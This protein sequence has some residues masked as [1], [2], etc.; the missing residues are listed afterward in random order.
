MVALEIFKS[1]WAFTPKQRWPA[2]LTLIKSRSVVENP[3]HTL[4]RHRALCYSGKKVSMASW[5]LL[6]WKSWPWRQGPPRLLRKATC[7][8]LHGKPQT[9]SVWV[10]TRSHQLV[11][12]PQS[13]VSISGTLPPTASSKKGR[14]SGKIKIAVQSGKQKSFRALLH[15]MAWAHS[16][17]WSA[18]SCQHQGQQKGGK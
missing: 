11:M 7:T 12:T 10:I 15:G 5:A 2:T 9:K 14:K 6:S 16:P 8:L 17:K 13:A 1:R 4:S 18:C 3:S